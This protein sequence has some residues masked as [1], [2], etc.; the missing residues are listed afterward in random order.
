MRAL[1]ILY[2]GTILNTLVLK[3]KD[4]STGVKCI[5]VHNTWGHERDI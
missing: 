1:V 2:I 3:H 4:V 5:Y